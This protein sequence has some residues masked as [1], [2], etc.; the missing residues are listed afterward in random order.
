M[1]INNTLFTIRYHQK[2]TLGKWGRVR[3]L[4]KRHTMIDNRKLDPHLIKLASTTLSLNQEETNEHH[5]LYVYY[6]VRTLKQ[7]CT[8]KIHLFIRLAIQNIIP[9]FSTTKA[10]EHSI[11]FHSSFVQIPLILLI[12]IAPVCLRP[13]KSVFV[14]QLIWRYDS[15]TTWHKSKQGRPPQVFCVLCP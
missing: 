5:I 9:S 4:P 1:N 14:R 7:K 6:C 13:F 11:Y 10:G 8:H 3:K 2:S 12:I 15:G